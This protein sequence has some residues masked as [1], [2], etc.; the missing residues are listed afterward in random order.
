[1]PKAQKSAQIYFSEFKD[2]RRIFTSDRRV[3]LCLHYEI[4]V[5]NDKRSNV[6]QCHKSPEGRSFI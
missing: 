3:L 6:V 5:G 2:I 4:K 1:M